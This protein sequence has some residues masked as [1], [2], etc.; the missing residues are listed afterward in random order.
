[1]NNNNLYKTKE[2]KKLKFILMG[3]L[4]VTV[5]STITMLL[6]N[7]L[8]PRIFGIA[9]INFWQAL[10]FLA[11]SRILFGGMGAGAMGRFHHHPHNPIREKWTKMTPEQQRRFIDKRMHFGFGNH[12]HRDNFDK[13]ECEDVEKK[14]A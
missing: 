13:D 14:D 10:G 8:L 6:W 1:M 11:L 9:S 12:Y 7:V 5:L 2:M 4:A 3:L